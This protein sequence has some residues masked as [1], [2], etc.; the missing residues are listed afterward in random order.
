[1][2]KKTTV[3]PFTDTQVEILNDLLRTQPARRNWERGLPNTGGPGGSRPPR[4]F[5][6][7]LDEMNKALGVS[8]ISIF[9]EVLFTGPTADEIV[10]ASTSDIVRIVAINVTEEFTDIGST[11][12][13]GTDADPD[14]FAEIDLSDLSQACLH[15][16]PCYKQLAADSTIKYFLSPGAS[17]AG[18]AEVTL[19]LGQC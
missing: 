9:K 4:G 11:L 17:L 13:I 19:T 8:D 3:A 10:A 6:T 7:I 1:M 16:I 14:A 5:G 12:T 2:G 15:V 18:R